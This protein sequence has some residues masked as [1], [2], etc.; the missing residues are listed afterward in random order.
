MRRRL[1]LLAL[2]LGLTVLTIVWVIWAECR[3]SG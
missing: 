1:L 3:I 2:G